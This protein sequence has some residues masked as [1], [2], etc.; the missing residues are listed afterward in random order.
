MKAVL[1]ALA[2]TRAR[3]P[4][5]AH[6]IAPRAKPPPIEVLPGP[7]DYQRVETARTGP[8]FTIATRWAACACRCQ[9]TQCVCL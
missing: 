5:P 4:G 8:A 6:T 9:G 7:A 3:T 2:C 1:L